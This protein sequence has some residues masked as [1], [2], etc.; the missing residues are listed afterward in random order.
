MRSLIRSFIALSA[1]MVCVLGP[2]AAEAA[3]SA[4]TYDLLVHQGTGQLQAG[5][6]A[7]ALAVA[8]EAIKSRP[9]RW[10][11]Y[12][13]AG[14]A[15]MNLKRYE[16]AA[17]RLSDAIER[18]PADK[19]SALR[20]LRRRALAE[21][22]PT[23]PTGSRAQATGAATTTT[24]AEIVMW[25]S[26]ENSTNPEDFQSYLNEYP[27]GAFAE[28]ALRHLTEIKARL[29][30]ERQ[31]EIMRAT[32][33]DPTTKLMW[34][35]TPLFI[36]KNEHGDAYD[37]FPFSEAVAYCAGTRIGGY[38]DWRLPTVNEILTIYGKGTSWKSRQIRDEVV[39]PKVFDVTYGTFSPVGKAA[40]RY[41][42]PWTSTPG[43]KDTGA[44]HFLID[45]GLPKVHRD[46]DGAVG[47]ITGGSAICVRNAK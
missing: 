26:I 5:N 4:N 36:L 18:A 12:V 2:V 13:L 9:Q 42:A 27:A 25:K 21:E 34:Y 29:G 41:L 22:S 32:W 6:A 40:Y 7:R 46:K 17:D 10:E 23:A 16:D 35:R 28:L 39:D 3:E 37:R 20:E 44:T 33:T 14:G 45:R 11:G 43:P 24:Q 30:H 38:D 8:E 19:Q 1:I 15:L 31:D 47:F